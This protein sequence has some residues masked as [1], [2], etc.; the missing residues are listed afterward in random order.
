MLRKA[1]TVTE[2]AD[3]ITSTYLVKGYAIF[4]D[5]WINESDKILYDGHNNPY[6]VLDF[7][8]IERP[9]YS[10]IGNVP[11]GS[12]ALG[13]D[14]WKIRKFSAIK[15]AEEVKVGDIFYT[16]INPEL[17]QQLTLW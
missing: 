9:V 2:I 15:F 8:T 12:L 13:I 3:G 7:Q 1:N 4:E 14:P 10:F 11:M 6:P 5:S 17:E 16:D